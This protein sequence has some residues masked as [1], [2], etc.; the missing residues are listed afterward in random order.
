MLVLY[1]DVLIITNDR[2]T[3]GRKPP[4]TTLILGMYIIKPSYR[5]DSF[6]KEL[7]LGG[8]QQPIHEQLSIAREE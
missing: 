1:F 7:L 5:L 4:R 3:Y 8:N 2:S 6:W